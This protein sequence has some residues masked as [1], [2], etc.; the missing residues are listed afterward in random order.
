MVHGR[1]FGSTFDLRYDLATLNPQ[2]D[3]A[4]VW[5]QLFYGG[6]VLI[7]LA[8]VGFVI[9]ALGGDLVLPALEA[10]GIIALI[11][12]ACVVGRAKRLRAFMFKNTGG[13]YAFEIVGAGQDAGRV[14]QFVS[15][16][17]QQIRKARGE[18]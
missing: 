16:V 1:R 11:G 5:A 14:E 2:F 8:L 3:Q 10:L 18:S 9:L 12:L 6:L 7:G 17:S 15:S 4:R 13:I